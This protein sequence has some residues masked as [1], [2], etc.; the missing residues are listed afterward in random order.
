LKP[1]LLPAGLMFLLLLGYAGLTESL[2][3]SSDRNDPG[4]MRK[5]ISRTSLKCSPDW[6]VN[7]LNENEVSE[8]ILLPGTGS[9]VW[10]IPTNSD[11]A[12]LYFNQGINLYYGFHIVEAIPSFKKALL[13]DST[14]AMLY[15][16]VALAYGPNINDMGYTAS[17]DALAAVTKAKF[18][19]D[20]APAKEKGLIDAMDA[21]YSNDSFAD[22]T[23]LNQRY[24]G[25]MKAL[26]NKY[27]D[28]AEIG[29]LYADA[30]MNL[31]P[32]DF[33]KHNGDPQPWT[34]DLIRL[35]KQILKNDPGHPGANHYFIHTM[36]ASPRAAEA[37]ASADRLASLTPGLAH[38]VHMPSHIYIRTGKYDKGRTTNEAAVKNYYAYRK[39]F[40]A[41]VNSAYLYEYH[42][43]HMQAASSM[44]MADYSVAIRDA[45][46]CR[47]SI[48]TAYLSVDPPFAEAIQYMY[49]TPMLTMVTFK[50]WKDILIEPLVPYQQHYGRLIQEFARGMAFAN[51]GNLVNAKYSLG[52]MDS[53]LKEK[54]MMIVLQ[55]FNAPVTGGTVAKYILMGTIA[56]KENHLTTAIQYFEKGV[57]TED[58]LVYQEPRDWL[59]PARHYL[60]KALLKQKKY[61]AAEK[62]FLKDLQ[63]QPDNFI[64]KTGLRDSKINKD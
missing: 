27:P 13:F 40:P 21:H 12:L 45:R 2:R 51:T 39:L 23:L 50:H 18:Y 32:W 62:V 31:H 5:K 58:G 26:F 28:D 56:E 29:T 20:K 35:L 47:Q 37:G 53:L 36:E 14:S 55:P 11:S 59:V 42:N 3:P 1:V 15:W 41:V 48:D 63:Y 19:R 22:R 60:G 49:M 33:W 24:A 61:T 46:E 43:L 54:N 38:M 64:S 25:K 6:S 4:E 57:A 10:K 7:P 17:P 9:H 8:M 16:A 52:I 44:N 34:P 30:L